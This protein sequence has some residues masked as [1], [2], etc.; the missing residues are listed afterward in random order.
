MEGWRY[1]G[2][3]NVFWQRLVGYVWSFATIAPAVFITRELIESFLPD[4]R[5]PRPSSLSGRHAR[6]WLYVIVGAACV[7]SPFV[8]PRDVARYLWAPVWCGF[9]L[10]IDPINERLGRVSLMRDA[11]LG[12]GRRIWALLVAGLVCGMLWEFWNYWATAKWIYTFPFPWLR[13]AK[14]FEMPVAGFLGFPPFALELF[15]MVEL[16]SALWRGSAEIQHRK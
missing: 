3:P 13:D 12:R 6:F 8:V 2:M 9:F 15:V 16:V 14:L 5:P 1:V 4:Q 7:I 10:L 11:R